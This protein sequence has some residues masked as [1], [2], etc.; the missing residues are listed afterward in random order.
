M[1]EMTATAVLRGMMNWMLPE[2][3]SENGKLPMIQNWAAAKAVPERMKNWMLLERKSENG[4]LLM[5]L[6][7]RDQ[8]LKA[9]NGL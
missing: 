5:M 8:R 6:R 4:K 1:L 2:R 9:E 7:I 3:K